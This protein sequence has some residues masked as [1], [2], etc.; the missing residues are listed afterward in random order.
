MSPTQYRTLEA[1]LAAGPAGMP[2]ARGMDVPPGRVHPRTVDA[3][4]RR[5][6]AEIQV[7]VDESYA[8]ITD[9]GIELLARNPSGIPTRPGAPR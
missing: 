9:A 6:L 2:I 4:V 3:L 5:G 8:V 1:L 7:Y